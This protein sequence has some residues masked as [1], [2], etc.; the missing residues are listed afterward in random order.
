MTTRARFL[1]TA[2]AA[3]AA[4]GMP[5]IVRA[6]ARKPLGIGYVPSTLFAPVFVAYEKGYLREAGFDATLTPIVAGQDAM[7]LAAQGQLDVVAAAM[8]AAFFNA[9]SHGLNVKFVA[10]TAYQPRKGAPSALLVRQDLYDGGLRDVAGLK[11]K[12]IGWIGGAGAASAYYVARILR[13]ANLHLSDIDAQ[14]IA[15]PDMELALERKAVDAV[16]TGAPFTLL[17]Q[18]KHDAKQL[19]TVTPGISASGV[20]FGPTLLGDPAHAKAVLD[21]LRRAARDIAGSGYYDAANMDTYIKYTKLAADVVKTSPRY[22][23]FGDLR[24]DG[25]TVEDMQREFIADGVL[26]YKDPLPEA[27]LVAR[28]S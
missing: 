20:F 16:F 13:T 12:K 9:V 15:N 14:N 26:T 6:Q 3:S 27:K 4:F 10:S 23:I 8:S 7:A 2:A 25:A 1:G 11:G 19:A 5:A 22:D 24:V 17:L 18:D 21:A 28:F